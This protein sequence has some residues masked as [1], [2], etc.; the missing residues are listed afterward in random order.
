MEG[1]EKRERRLGGRVRSEYLGGTK[2]VEEGLV[3][4]RRG[5]AKTRVSSGMIG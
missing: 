4:R 2:S 1:L 5:G 3:G